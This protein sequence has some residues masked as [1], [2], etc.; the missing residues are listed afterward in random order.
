M[1]IEDGMN[2]EGR[3]PARPPLYGELRFV[4]RP[5]LSTEVYR[6]VRTQRQSPE[7]EWRADAAIIARHLVSWDLQTRAADGSLVLAPI[8][9]GILAKLPHAVFQQLLAHVQGY[10]TTEQERSEKN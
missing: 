5:A 4:Y 2:L 3:I 6:N 1:I 10:A 8:N 7:E 9:E